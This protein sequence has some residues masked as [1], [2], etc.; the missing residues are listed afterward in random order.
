MAKKKS[1][2]DGVFPTKDVWLNDMGAGDSDS[3][4]AEVWDALSVMSSGVSDM[5]KAKWA[6]W[7]GDGSWRSKKRALKVGSA[8]FKRRMLG[9][10][11]K[12]MCKQRMSQRKRL[13]L[14]QRLGG[15]GVEETASFPKK[16]NDKIWGFF[17]Q[18]RGTS[19]AHVAAGRAK[20][21]CGHSASS[22]GATLTKIGV[23]CLQ[24]ASMPVGFFP[25]ILDPWGEFYRGGPN[26]V[27]APKTDMDKTCGERGT[28]GHMFG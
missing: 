28:G 6:G 15:A 18:V 27:P 12:K 20:N 5:A 22:S 3:E 17:C 4:A 9:E 26:D 23:C 8:G 25:A 19:C 13:A 2:V 7:E 11:S 24:R 16:K 14:R 21:G 10:K 1:T